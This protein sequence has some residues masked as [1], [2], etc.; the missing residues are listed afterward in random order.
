MI[1]PRDGTDFRAK[2]KIKPSDFDRILGD[3]SSSNLIKNSQEEILGSAT[4]ESNILLPLYNTGG[5]LFPYTPQIQFGTSANYVE[6]AFDHSNYKQWAYNGSSPNAIVITALFTSQTTAEA[7]YTL[8]VWHFFNTVT[9]SYFGIK[10]P[11]KAGTPPPVL[12][13]NYLGDYIFNNLP[14]IV[15]DY[16]VTFDNNVNYVPVRVT[17]DASSSPG[18]QGISYVPTE[19]S[20]TI[21]LEIQQNPNKVRNEFDLDDFRS[22]KMLGRGFI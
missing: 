7:K 12:L 5:V 4:D 21:T 3:Q 20:C 10:S 11:G 13:F 9:K 17:P 15:K 2:L 16:N 18:Q 6:M 8:A 1:D 19:M 14:V 22:G